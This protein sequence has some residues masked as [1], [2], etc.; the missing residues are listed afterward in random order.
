[1]F[2]RLLV[3]IDDSEQTE[4]TL[5]FAIAVAQNCG[6]TVHLCFVNPFQVGSRG[7][8]LLSDA[9]ATE[10][11][12]R[13]IRRLRAEDIITSGSVRRAPC[14][15]IAEKIASAADEVSAE[16][17]ILGSHRRRRWARVFSSGVRERTTRLTTLPVLTSPAPL[18]LP[19]PRHCDVQEITKDQESRE[20][21]LSD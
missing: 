14:H 16:A 2:Q 4:I 6:S 12:V 11:V 15:R 9:E 17:I 10:V 20:Q 1:M 3:G 18:V 5:C 13:G 21:T 8:P 19:H 7:I